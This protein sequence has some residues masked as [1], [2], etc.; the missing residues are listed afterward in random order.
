MKAIFLDRDGTIIKEYAKTPNEVEP[1]P[2][3]L[4]ALRHLQEAGFELFLVSNQPD[5]SRGLLSMK[6]ASAIHHRLVRLLE[7][8]GI[9]FTS[10][11]YCFH[12]P[13]EDCTCRKPRVG[14]L[15]RVLAKCPDID[16]S[17][18]WMIGDRETDIQFGHAGGLRTIRL[19]PAFTLSHAVETLLEELSND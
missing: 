11:E 17:Q 13:E 14:M 7:N 12:K 3:A 2:G 19:I 10:F 18:S 1:I 9:F 16:L 8:N 4:E 6:T 15:K 5:V